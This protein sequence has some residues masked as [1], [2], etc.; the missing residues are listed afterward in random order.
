MA[1]HGLCR[2]SNDPRQG[3]GR[4]SA[5]S[6]PAR[7]LVNVVRLFTDEGGGENDGETDDCLF[8]GV[9]STHGRES[10]VIL[11]YKYRGGPMSLT[12][13]IAVNRADL[14]VGWLERAVDGA[15]ADWL[16]EARSA[17]P[18][19]TFSEIEKTMALAG[20]KAG[21]GPL[22]LAEDDL[23]DADAVRPGWVPLS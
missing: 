8:D 6:V 18:T 19:M 5:L 7:Q 21:K 22:V 9:L 4:E 12:E 16:A 14:I 10:W 17:A 15:V 23:A 3:N 2:Q 13:N 1:G 11:V 20:R